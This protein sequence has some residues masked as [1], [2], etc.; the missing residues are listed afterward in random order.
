[1]LGDGLELKGS[2]EG[3]VAD[4]YKH[5]DESSGSIKYGE[6]FD[7]MGVSRIPWSHPNLTYSVWFELHT[8]QHDNS[9]TSRYV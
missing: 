8:Y 2:G 4:S 3:P 1:M 5:G 6:C 9:N 7:Q